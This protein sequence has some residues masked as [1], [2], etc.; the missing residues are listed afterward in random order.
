MTLILG[1]QSPR[2]K[3][4]LNFFSITFKQVTPGFD[5][6]SVQFNG[7]PKAYATLISD[8]KSDW[9]AKHYPNELIL[10]ADTIVYQDGK[11]YGKPSNEQESFSHLKDLVGKWHSVFTSLTLRT[12]SEKHHIVEETR[13]QFNHL[14]DEQVKAYHLTLPCTDKAGGYMIQGAG[15][16]IVKKIEGCYYNVMGLPVNGLADVFSRVGIDLWQ[17]LKGN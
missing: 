9:L 14:T 6:E 12:P 16:L 11:V 8:G 5:E 7:D 15:S 2:R 17:H 13:V 10:T 4:I 3:E 1:S